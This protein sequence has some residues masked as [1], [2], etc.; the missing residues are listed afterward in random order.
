MPFTEDEMRALRS[1][2]QEEVQKEIR[3]LGKEIGQRFDEV[4]T[5]LDGLYRRDEKREQEY[6]SIR[7]Q[8]RRLE[9]SFG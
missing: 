5:Q 1:L 6:V 7:E 2:L 9:S 8:L 3:L 4:A